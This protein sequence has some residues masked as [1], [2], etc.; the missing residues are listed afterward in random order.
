MFLEQFYKTLGTTAI[1]T[2]LAKHRR[3]L[4]QTSAAD[5]AQQMLM[6]LFMLCITTTIPRAN[7]VTLIHLLCLRYLTVG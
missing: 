1:S 5:V 2:H 6:M 4:S 7:V 3:C